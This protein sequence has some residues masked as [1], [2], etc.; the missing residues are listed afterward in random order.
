M[1]RVLVW[2]V[3]GIAFAAI[4]VAHAQ[5]DS[6]DL[7]DDEADLADDEADLADDEVEFGI[8]AAQHGLW[9]EA[10]F[11]FERAIVLDPADAR[12]YNNL[13]VAYEQSGRFDDAVRMYER[14]LALDPDNPS[15]R[16]NYDQFSEINDRA[17]RPVRR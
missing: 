16:L 3:L 11:R 12:A 7:A 6:A 8:L 10:I 15:I 9:N 14:A 1:N 17:P 4:G 13:A 2:L 5:Q